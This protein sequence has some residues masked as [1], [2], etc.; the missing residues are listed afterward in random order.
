MRSCFALCSQ[1]VARPERGRLLRGVLLVPLWWFWGVASCCKTFPHPHPWT[2]RWGTWTPPRD[3]WPAPA[4]ATNG[5]TSSSD[6]SHRPIRT[7]PP[8][9][10]KKPFPMEWMTHQFLDLIKKSSVSEKNSRKK[11]KVHNK[12]VNEGAWLTYPSRL[13]SICLSHSSTSGFCR[14]TPRSMSFFLKYSTFVL[15]STMGS[16]SSDSPK[17]ELK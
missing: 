10:R 13:V 6:Q 3:P 9:Y 15:R 8:P 14:S 1:W 5:P 11:S 17:I 7:D 12:K 4:P 2:W 16:S